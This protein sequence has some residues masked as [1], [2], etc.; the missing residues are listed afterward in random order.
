M[1]PSSVRIIGTVAAWV[2]ATL[3]LGSS[4]SSAGEH[5]ARPVP[6]PTPTPSP[7]PLPQDPTPSPPPEPQIGFTNPPGASRSASGP[8]L[9]ITASV[10]H[11]YLIDGVDIELSSESG[12]S[13]TL[14]RASQLG[15]SNT[16][17]FIWDL[18]DSSLPGTDVTGSVPDD[19]YVIR[20]KLRGA[21]AVTEMPVM[22]RRETSATDTEG[23][24]QWAIVASPLNGR[25]ASFTEDIDREVRVSG[26]A[27]AGAE[28]VDLFYS[29]TAPGQVAEW[30]SAQCGYVG[31]SGT[32]TSTQS[33]E[34]T[35]QLDPVHRPEEVTAIAALAYNCSIAGCDASPAGRSGLGMGQREGGDAIRIHPCWGEPCISMSP[36][37]WRAGVGTCQ[38]V[39]ID[40]AS[41]SNGPQPGVNIDIH[42]SGKGARFCELKNQSQ[43]RAPDK[44]HGITSGQKHGTHR[45]EGGRTLHTEGE[46]DPNGR[47][48]FGVASTKASFD[49]VYDQFESSHTSIE[50]WAD[51]EDDDETGPGEDVQKAT[52][53]WELAGRCTI[54]GTEGDDIITGSVGD[55]IICGL[56]G[57]DTIY[58]Q[59]G[60]DLIRAGKGD[61]TV[62]GDEGNDAILGG[63]GKDT[64]F[65]GGG[66]DRLSGGR[67]DDTL[68]GGPGRDRI[69]GGPGR[70]ACRGGGPTNMVT[71]CPHRAQ[72]P[73][74]KEE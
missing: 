50:A 7:S 42:V 11:P 34:G 14:G 63:L 24:P 9:R 71:R 59:E 43:R 65:G 37:V 40:T 69:D 6:T 20:A 18:D 29:V 27:S 55:D 19:S 28:G 1:G 35:C 16:Y 70:N 74:Q 45:D 5:G 15:R 67:G 47:F 58:A 32:G 49:S 8:T 54:I 53:H 13:V 51:K 38:K 72:P 36:S 25:T 44:E 52:F 57:S 56:S 68:Y 3:L 64:L 23:V 4:W 12:G 22:V 61:D 66:R 31:L 2:A 48:I 39:V 33:F 10:D 26:T 30:Q 62:Y 41:L 60:A 46:S 73:P 17:E 21:A